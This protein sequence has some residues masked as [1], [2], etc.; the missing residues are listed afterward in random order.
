M[1][2]YISLALTPEEMAEKQEAMSTP[3]AA[4]LP[5]Y[6]YGLRISLRK[7][8]LNKLDL[9]VADWKVGMVFPV[10][11]MLEVVGINMNETQED[12]HVCV[13]MQIVA[14]KGEE[15][16]EEKE[17]AEEYDS[18]PSLERHGYLRYK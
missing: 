3:L 7:E 15:H 11:V 18:E 9:D 4:E 10:D 14:M 12:T 5:K 6:P 17:E 13:E 16:E 8:T 1:S 2:E